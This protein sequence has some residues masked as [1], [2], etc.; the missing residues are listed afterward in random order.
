MST[1]YKFGGYEPSFHWFKFRLQDLA[2]AI[3]GAK[4]VLR[5][6]DTKGPVEVTL[7]IGK[8]GASS[9]LL[10]EAQF[11]VLWHVHK[12]ERAPNRVF[13][14]RDFESLSPIEFDG[15]DSLLRKLK[16]LTPRKTKVDYDTSPANRVFHDAASAGDGRLRGLFELNRCLYRL[17][18][19]GIDPRKFAL[20][21]ECASKIRICALVINTWTQ[22][23]RSADARKRNPKILDVGVTS[24]DS[25]APTLQAT[26]TSTHFVVKESNM[27]NKEARKNF[28][29]GASKEATLV[30]I[31]SQLRSLLLAGPTVLLVAGA[32]TTE[33][34]LNAIDIDTSSWAHGIK[35]LVQNDIAQPAP[36]PKPYYHRED[37]PSTSQ[38]HRSRSRSPTRP[39]SNSNSN[40]NSH[41]L[42]HSSRSSTAT[43][44]RTASTVPRT[45]RT[46]SE[47]LPSPRRREYLPV[48]MVDVQ[49]MYEKLKKTGDK[50]SI[51]R[52]AEYLQVEAPVGTTALGN[53]AASGKAASGGICAGNEARLLIDIWAAMASGAAIDEQHEERALV[54]RQR[55]ASRQAAPSQSGT[56][57]EPAATSGSLASSGGYD[58]DDDDDADPFTSMQQAIQQ[59]ES[60]GVNP[61]DDYY[62]IDS[63]HGSDMD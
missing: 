34:I 62:D 37:G 1:Y 16:R 52:I 57:V 10:N 5:T 15:A 43:S 20:N 46:P 47:S 28:N 42:H 32:D 8:S 45:S 12:R 49:Q 35:S 21:D 31:A 36:P 60:S 26:R 50:D 19:G 11:Q 13:S 22:D 55:E 38:S 53:S 3:A 59:Q 24:V 18:N 33:D 54:Q 51:Y 44:S 58:D 41:L 61:G 29:Y 39:T 14:P 7:G 30:D 2:E 6:V 23:G 27:L 48:Y 63:D 17:I 25:S 4:S 9:L 40:S 56:K